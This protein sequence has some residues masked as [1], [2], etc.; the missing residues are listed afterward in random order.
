VSRIV[1]S[2]SCHDPGSEGGISSC[3]ADEN[4]GV[5]AMSESTPR[6][7]MGFRATVGR[8]RPSCA[9]SPQVRYPL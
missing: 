1:M 5:E 6:G 3:E 2:P 8:L 9:Q 4:G 7:N